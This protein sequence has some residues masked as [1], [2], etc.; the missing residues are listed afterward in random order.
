V[1]RCF[2]LDYAIP[3]YADQRHRDDLDHRLFALQLDRAAQCVV[4]M[5]LPAVGH[6]ICR[7]C[8]APSSHSET[9]FNEINCG[10]SAIQT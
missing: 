4:A 10:I 1:S 3:E 9:R 2:W 7:I 6:R 8:L 5:A